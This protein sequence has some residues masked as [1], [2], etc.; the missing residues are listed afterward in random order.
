M[1]CFKLLVTPP[2]LLTPGHVIVCADREQEQR[3]QLLCYGYHRGSVVYTK[4]YSLA[5]LHEA[6]A[7]GQDWCVERSHPSGI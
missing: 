6:G 3:L 5:S 4:E 2:A 7:Q 1:S